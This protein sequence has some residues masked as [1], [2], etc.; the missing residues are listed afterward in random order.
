VFVLKIFARSGGRALYIEVDD[1]KVLTKEYKCS[2]TGLYSC[3]CWL[4][5]SETCKRVS[6][7]ES[8]ER[9]VKMSLNETK[10]G[11]M[12]EVK[13]HVKQIVKQKVKRSLKHVRIKNKK[14]T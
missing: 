11:S 7:K 9:G 8:G 14:V 6:C 5:I 10:G 4:N 2:S 13:R 12:Q 3:S 1:Y